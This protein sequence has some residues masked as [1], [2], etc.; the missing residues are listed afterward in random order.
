MLT[1]TGIGAAAGYVFSLPPFKN[2]GYKA[3]AKFVVPESKFLKRGVVGREEYDGFGVGHK[4]DVRRM[5]AV[6]QSPETEMRVMDS[7]QIPGHYGYMH[8]NEAQW[9]EVTDI[10]RDNVRFDDP[11]SNYVLIEVWDESPEFAKRIAQTLVHF[12]GEY[13]RNQFQPRKAAE[14]L[15]V[16]RE[17]FSLVET[18][19][20]ALLYDKRREKR[21]HYDHMS[22]TVS[23][24][25]DFHAG[26]AD[27]DELYSRE[28]RLDVLEKKGA[29]NDAR[30][31]FGREWTRVFD[32]AGESASAP[33]ETRFNDKPDSLVFA[34]TGA[35]GGALWAFACVMLIRL[36]RTA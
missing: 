2:P 6:L 7:L 5:L 8:P 34:L 33:M 26:H 17:N 36:I 11:K 35:V 25:L 1:F 23:R 30:S 3:T 32:F 24:G 12:A 4:P 18:T 28:Y 27:Y 14:E 13:W 15:I 29:Y 21:Y 20:R 19:E 9:K 22:E 31:E 10:Y 16:S